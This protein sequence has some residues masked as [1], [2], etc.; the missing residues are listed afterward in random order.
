MF[1]PSVLTYISIQLVPT[2]T[3]THQLVA[4]VKYAIL[5]DNQP[6]H[7]INGLCLKWFDLNAYWEKQFTNS[8]ILSRGWNLQHFQFN[9]SG[10]CQTVSTISCNLYCI[11][12]LWWQYAELQPKR[13]KQQCYN[14]K[15]LPLEPPSV[16]YLKRWHAVVIS[17]LTYSSLNWCQQVHISI[18]M[19]QRQDSILCNTR[20]LKKISL[21]L[22]YLKWFVCFIHIKVITLWIQGLIFVH[23]QGFIAQNEGRFFLIIRLWMYLSRIKTKGIIAYRQNILENV[24]TL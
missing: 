2:S 6:T 19:Y 23:L 18:H 1:P 11:S 5:K 21:K 15:K 13:T 3:G 4:I 20:S 9:F 8:F 22:L 14:W 7:T 24:L 16:K 10:F 12:K 17:F